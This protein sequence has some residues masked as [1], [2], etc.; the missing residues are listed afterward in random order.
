MMAATPVFQK[1]RSA[2]IGLHSVR[3][4]DQWRV[5]FHWTAA[6]PTDVDILDYH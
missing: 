1:H 3:I 4:N 6:G 2:Q 5:T